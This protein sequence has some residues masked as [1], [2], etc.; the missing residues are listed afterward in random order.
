MGA[1]MDEVGRL[2]HLVFL[3]RTQVTLDCLAP[4]DPSGPIRFL[5]RQLD[6]YFRGACRTFNV[7]LRPAG[8]AEDLRIWAAITTIPYGERL[9]LERLA[10]SLSIPVDEVSLALRRNPLAL[11]V[12]C[13]RVANRPEGDTPH[14]ATLLD[15]EQGRRPV[16]IG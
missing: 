13:H 11:I 2:S 10:T 1:R 15:L 7:P 3:N 14:Q 4:S 8:S 12:P 5:Q 6:D 16:L 9:S